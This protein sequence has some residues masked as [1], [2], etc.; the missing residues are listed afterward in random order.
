MSNRKQFQKKIE[1]AIKDKYTNWEEKS[2]IVDKLMINEENSEEY[3]VDLVIKHKN[4]KIR[5]GVAST[6][7]YLNKPEIAEKLVGR[8]LIEPNWSVRYALSKACAKHLGK[9]VIESLNQY[10]LQLYAQSDDNRKF[11]LRKIFAETLGI[12]ELKEGMSFLV[13]Q[14]EEIGNYRDKYSV[15]LIMQILY[16]L[17]EV[18]D[19]SIVSL[20][21][22]YSA[23][24]LYSTDSIINSASHAIEKIAKR[25]GFSTK[26][27]LLDDIN[28]D[29]N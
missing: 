10:Y 24:N 12:I 23:R 21:L 18:G 8:I 15:E 25:L 9:D 4:P 28:K 3:F 20:L 1:K 16:S 29:Q 13:S 17:G 19:R 2:A 27:A 5:K 6:L 22:K 26:K 11:Q 7:L 14:L